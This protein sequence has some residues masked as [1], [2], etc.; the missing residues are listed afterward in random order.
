MT[1]RANHRHNFSIE[2]FQSPRRG[3]G[4]GLLNRT[5][6]RHFSRRNVAS[7]CSRRQ[8]SGE[9]KPAPSC[10][11]NF[12]VLCVALRLKGNGHEETAC[13]RADCAGI[14]FVRGKSTGARRKCGP[15]CRVGRRR[16]GTSRRSGRRVHRICR[17][18]V[19]RAL[20]G[21]SAI[22]IAIPRKACNAIRP[23]TSPTGGCR[24]EFAA[25][26]QDFTASRQESRAAAGSRI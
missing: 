15:G 12:A 9:A 18:A 8:E 16:A 23:R 24:G 10:R 5:A 3:T 20:L 4:C 6:P 21:N 13:C 2:K 14:C 22:R 11:R 7:D 1:R 26:R 25:T 17:G 19:D